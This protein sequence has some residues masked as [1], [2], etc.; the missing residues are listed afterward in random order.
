MKQAGYETEDQLLDEIILQYKKDK[1]V[2]KYAEEQ[3]TDE[4][5]ENYYNENIFGEITAKH[6]LIKP[7]TTS[8]MSDEEKKS[9]KMKL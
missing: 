9:K 4:E 1:V 3:I 2:E 6:I 8:T 7:E 5:V